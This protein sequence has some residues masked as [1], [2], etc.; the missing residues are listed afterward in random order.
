MILAETFV[1]LIK[2]P[3]HWMFEGVTD[4]IFAGAGAIVARAWVKAHDIR[5]HGHKHCEDVHE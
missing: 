5:A 3:S 4:L 1:E 2:D